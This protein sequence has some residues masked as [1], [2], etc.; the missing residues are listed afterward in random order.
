MFR[1]RIRS[2]LLERYEGQLFRQMADNLPVTTTR[3]TGYATKSPLN[4]KAS[5]SSSP[6]SS[7]RITATTSAAT[8]AAAAAASPPSRNGGQGQGKEGAA[9][10]AE[11]A[12]ALRTAEMRESALRAARLRRLA[13]HQDRLAEEEKKREE[14]RE[15]KRRYDG[16]ARRWV[17]TIIALPILLVTSYY[18]FDRLVLGKKAKSLEK[19]RGKKADSDGSR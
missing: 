5:S 10:A 13:Q 3:R 2:R 19:Y 15:Y 12:A 14:K 11:A 4:N 6:S 7:P 18:L 1:S 17:S 8:A 16:A 9:A